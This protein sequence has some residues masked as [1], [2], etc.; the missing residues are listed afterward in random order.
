MPGDPG[1]DPEVERITVNEIV[2]ALMAK[3]KELS[4]RIETLEQQ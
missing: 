1:G 3:V 2:T 4:A